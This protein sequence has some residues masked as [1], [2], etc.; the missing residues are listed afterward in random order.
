MGNLKFILI[1][2]LALNLNAQKKQVENDKLIACLSEPKFL[3]WF[4]ICK[5]ETDTVYIYN[6]IE[7]FKN[8][9]SIKPS[10]GKLL[11]LQKSSFEI[12]VDKGI[13][14]C[15]DKIVLYKYEVEK[16]KYKL[17]F[18]NICSNAHMVIELNSKNKIINYSTGI[19]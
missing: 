13:P 11:V 9:T 4:N 17:S 10:C 16:G 15:G 12:N 3:S 18:L 8:F 7:K 19:F 5:K 14:N 2:F 6:N 1:A